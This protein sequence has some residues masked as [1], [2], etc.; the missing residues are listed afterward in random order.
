MRVLVIDAQAKAG[1]A[2]VVE[3]SSL[4]ENLYVPGPAAK[5]PGDMKE[6]TLRLGDYKIVFSLTKD[7]STGDV[8]RHLSISVP[9]KG[10]FPH[11]AVVNEVLGL[12]GFKG[13]LSNCQA[14]VNQVEGCIVVAQVLES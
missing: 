14:D 2:K 11:P 9:T 12:F 7:P 10:A 4:P 6:H 5:I 1:A 8:Y 3:Y 13:G